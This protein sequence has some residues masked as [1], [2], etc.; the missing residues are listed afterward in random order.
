MF[1]VQPPAGQMQP[2]YPI[3]HSAGS[4]VLV[5]IGHLNS[6]HSMDS[7]SENVAT[8]SQPSGT[9]PMSEHTF[10]LRHGKDIL[11]EYADDSHG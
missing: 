9:D 11:I 6:Y 10:G 3:L 8:A 7:P 2:H 1:C 5:F 4:L